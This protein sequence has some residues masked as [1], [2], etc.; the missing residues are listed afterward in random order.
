MSSFLVARNREL[1][2]HRI[3]ILRARLA[4]ETPGEQCWFHPGWLFWYRGWN[5]NQLYGDYF[6]NHYKDPVLSQ[7]IE[8]Y[9]GD[10]GGLYYPTIW[11]GGGNSNIFGIFTPKIGEMVQFDEHIF[12]LGWNHQLDGD[13]DKPWNKDPY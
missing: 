2:D 6:I 12:Q 11:L 4:A 1:M 7:H 5:T 10:G 9:L 13:Y 3:N 8:I